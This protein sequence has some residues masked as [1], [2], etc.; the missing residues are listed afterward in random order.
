[1][2]QSLPINPD[3]ELGFLP[4]QVRSSDRR[5]GQFPGFS[6]ERVRLPD[7][8]FEYRMSGTS[9]YL[10]LH[11]IELSEGEVEV[12]GGVRSQTR[13]LVDKLTFAPAGCEITGWS[14]PKARDNNFTAL[15]FDPKTLNEEL[16]NDFAAQAPAPSLYFRNAELESTM[17]KLAKAISVQANAVYLESLSISA[18][19]EVLQIPAMGVPGTF[20]AT[21]LNRLIDYVEAHL[22]EDLS[23]GDMANAVGLSRFHFS[24][25]FR[26]TTSETP[27]QF[28]LQRRV[29]KARDL[30]LSS[31]LPLEHIATICGFRTLAHFD[32]AFRRIVGTRPFAFRGK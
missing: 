13:S 9:H 22:A 17:K 7:E 28:L 2:T 19:S 23:V 31:K 6:V 27:Y 5:L 18:A 14:K 20:S 12:S 16:G 10:A 30:L 11:D 1:M 15:Y 29:Q 4:P 24:R 3:L 26:Q 21:E 32:E 8:Q 25:V